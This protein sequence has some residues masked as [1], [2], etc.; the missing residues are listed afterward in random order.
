MIVVIEVQEFMKA[1]IVEPSLSDEQRLHGYRWL[2]ENAS[3]SAFN[4]LTLQIVL[5]AWDPPL[6]SD[7]EKNEVSWPPMVLEHWRRLLIR[8]AVAV[9]LTKSD[10]DAVVV[11]DADGNRGRVISSDELREIVEAGYRSAFFGLYVA[12]NELGVFPPAG[13]VGEWHRT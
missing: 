4:D 2:R 6:T 3:P 11:R 13:K 5:S 9:L 12:D 10:A 8:I 1:L 7:D